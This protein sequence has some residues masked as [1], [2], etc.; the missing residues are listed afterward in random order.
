MIGY[1]MLR[2]LNSLK[3]KKCIGFIINVIYKSVVENNI[4]FHIY[5]QKMLA[6]I[7]HMKTK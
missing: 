4:L 7:I 1:V 3:I 6:Y 5:L 2:I